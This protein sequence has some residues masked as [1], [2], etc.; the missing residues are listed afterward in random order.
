MTRSLLLT[1]TLAVLLLAGC[2][3]SEGEG[4]AEGIPECDKLFRMADACFSKNPVVKASMADSV[5][6]V[7]EMLKPKGNAPLERAR[8]ADVCRQRMAGLEQACR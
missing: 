2:E 4:G 1:L 7:R 8:I 5:D 3:P 6:Q